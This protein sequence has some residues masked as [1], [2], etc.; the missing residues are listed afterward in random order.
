MGRMNPNWVAGAT[1]LIAGLIWSGGNGWWLTALGAWTL[2]GIWG[3][4]NSGG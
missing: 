4:S 1:F 2:M 3:Q